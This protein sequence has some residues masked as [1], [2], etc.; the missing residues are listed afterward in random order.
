VKLD[1]YLK[2]PACLCGS[3]SPT[4]FYKDL[5]QYPVKSKRKLG[6]L[7]L[8]ANQKA[9]GYLDFFHLSRGFPR[10]IHNQE[11]WDVFNRGSVMLYFEPVFLRLVEV[12]KLSNDDRTLLMYLDALSR[13]SIDQWDQIVEGIGA[14]CYEFFI[15][16]PETYV[17][18]IRRT[19]A[20]A[21][22][23]LTDHELLEQLRIKGPFLE[24]G[25]CR[26]DLIQRYKNSRTTDDMSVS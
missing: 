11:V 20:E 6:E 9:I 2:T 10:P 13:T 7:I 15:N 21:A 1:T 19:N 3:F 18:L 22:E 24:R 4:V 26:E 12:E 25:K 14:C 16:E 5:F 8:A 23:E 17:R